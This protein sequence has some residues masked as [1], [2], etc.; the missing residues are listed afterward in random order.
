[1]KAEEVGCAL[2]TAMNARQWW[3]M[4]TLRFCSCQITAHG[5]RFASPALPVTC[6][7]SY[8]FQRGHTP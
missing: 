8:R 7:R 2:R 5:S 6:E 1:M 4:P 3:A